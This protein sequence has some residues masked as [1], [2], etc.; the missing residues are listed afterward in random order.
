MAMDP[1][2][3]SP[4]YQP[5]GVDK[6]L[7]SAQENKNKKPAENLDHTSLTSRPAQPADTM[8]IS[9]AAHRLVELRSAVDTGRN[10]LEALPDVRDD[11]V[12][13]AKKRLEQGFYNSSQVRDE[14]AVKL[15]SVFDSMDEL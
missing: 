3:G 12:A 6:F 13:L 11:R 2:N 5:G 15:G 4:M 7:N 14:V 9:D 8:E 1:I 10:A